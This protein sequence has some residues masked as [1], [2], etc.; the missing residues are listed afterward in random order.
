MNVYLFIHF[1]LIS[2]FEG[3]GVEGIRSVVAKG[4]IFK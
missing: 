3:Q 4:F 1:M 2:V